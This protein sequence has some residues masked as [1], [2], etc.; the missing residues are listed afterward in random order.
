MSARRCAFPSPSDRPAASVV[1]PGGGAGMVIGRRAFLIALGMA[2]MAARAAL[3]A[4]GLQDIGGRANM[5]FGAAVQAR[6]ILT[7]PGFRAHVL[8]E[9]G[10]ITPEI[11]LKWDFIDPEPGAN[12][13]TPADQLARFAARNGK[14]L[15]GHA[16]LWHKSIPPWAVQQMADRPDWGAVSGFMASVI[17]RYAGVADGWDVV[18]EPLEPNGRPDGLRASPFLAAF[19]PDYIRRAFDE[20]RRLAPRARLFLNEYGLDYDRP[21]CQR[22]RE[23]LLRLLDELGRTG[24]PI[25]GIGLQLHLEL[26]RMAEFDERI[27]A[28][29]LNELGAR[30]L[31]IRISELDVAE[32][33]TAIPVEERDRR[34]AEAVRRVLDVAIANRAVGSI[35]CWGLSDRYSWLPPPSEQSGLNRGL[36][37]DSD[38]KRKEIYLAIRDA[39]RQREAL[40]RK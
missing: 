6:Q 34:C 4:P 12:Q 33:E 26:A 13:F 25:D 1:L 38:L 24:A 16:L 36:P 8:H 30:G 7:D 3:P 10:S 23:A 29:F 32:A 18:N 14:R 31:Q 40:L 21:D 17:P 11:E 37:L 19:G 39:F 2:P 28:A 35:T 15:H 5:L 20:A 9:C 27:F 22:K